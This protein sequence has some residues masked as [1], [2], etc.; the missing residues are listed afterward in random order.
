MASANLLA[1]LSDMFPMIA[2]AMVSTLSRFRS[3]SEPLVSAA[4]SFSSRSAI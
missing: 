4:A 1:R 2:A 3:N